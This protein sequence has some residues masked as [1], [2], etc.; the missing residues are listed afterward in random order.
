MTMSSS[1]EMRL[2]RR[3]PS[4]TPAEAAEKLLEIEPDDAAAEERLATAV[5]WGYGTGWGLAR[6]A[7]GVVGIV[8]GAAS[9]FQFAIVWGAGLV[10]LPNLKLTPPP[11]R[12]SAVELVIDGWHHLVYA[13]A[14]GYVYDWLAPADRE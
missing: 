4:T 5:H 8:G 7:L 11:Q 13:A 12:W 14:A 1:V 3:P 10:M 2:R 9:A 6:G